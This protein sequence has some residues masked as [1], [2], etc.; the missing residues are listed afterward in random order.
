MEELN[1]D[2]DGARLFAGQ[3]TNSLSNLKGLAR[4]LP[5]GKAGVRLHDLPAL[6][7]LLRPDGSITRIAAILL[8]GEARAVRALLLDK[9]IDT[10]WSLEWHQ[11]RTIC[12][13]KKREQPGFGPWSVKE[14]MHHVEPPFSLLS[15]MVTLRVHIDAVPVDNAPLLVALGSNCV[16]RIAQSKIDGVI[17]R[18]RVMICTAAAG[19]IWAYATPILH[20]SKAATRPRHRRVLQVDF[21]ADKLPGELEWLGV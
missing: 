6:S 4:S 3:A 2:R 14:G 17:A 7:E 1:F 5:P 20:A 16:G 19:D 13:S 9:T 21:S 10:N 8:E 12:V 11:D 15:R 18:S